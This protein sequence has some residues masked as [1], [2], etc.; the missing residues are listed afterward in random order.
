LW[1]WLDGLDLDLWQELV[2]CRRAF[3]RGMA[4][5]NA[6]R[7]SRKRNEQWAAKQLG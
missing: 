2:D 5:V 3:D 4:E 1:V 6:E 7:A